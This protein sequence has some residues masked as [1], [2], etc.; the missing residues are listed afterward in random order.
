MKSMTCFTIV[1]LAAMTA[2]PVF[3]D[4]VSPEE[5][6]LQ[7]PASPSRWRI[8]AGVRFAPGIKADANISTKAIADS[9]GRLRPLGTSWTTPVPKEFS[10]TSTTVS[11]EKSSDSTA[12]KLDLASGGRVD[13]DVGFIDMSDDAGIPG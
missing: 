7:N 13:F 1:A 8:S 9:V 2:L 6:D 4:D 11:S 3:A 5:V 12:E 10:S